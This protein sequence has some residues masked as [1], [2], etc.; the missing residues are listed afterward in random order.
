MA[1][2]VAKVCSLRPYSQSV[3]IHGHCAREIV[4]RSHV[5]RALNGTPETTNMILAFVLP[6]MVE[7]SKKNKTL[8][9]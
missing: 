7:S 5:G 4:D 6:G 8:S 9:A 1:E 3:T 2:L